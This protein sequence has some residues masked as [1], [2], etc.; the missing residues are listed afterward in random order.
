MLLDDEVQPG[1]ATRQFRRIE[2][3]PGMPACVADAG[4]GS[5]QCEQRPTLA[6]AG[7]AR[8]QQAAD[9]EHEAQRGEADALEDAERARQDPQFELHVER[10]REQG[11]ADREAEQGL[12]AERPA[13]GIHGMPV[14]P[15]RTDYLPLP[16]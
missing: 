1:A 5:D 4:A 7:T 14:R 6:C 3:H 11:G 10:V 9:Q 12:R 15:G 16:P 8:R 13:E 2:L